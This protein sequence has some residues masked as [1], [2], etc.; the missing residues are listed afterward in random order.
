MV[1]CDAIFSAVSGNREME[2]PQDGTL[3]MITAA[4]HSRHSYKLYH[5]GENNKPIFSSKSSFKIY[6]NQQNA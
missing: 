5:L 4:G 3:R 1:T 2:E 6:F